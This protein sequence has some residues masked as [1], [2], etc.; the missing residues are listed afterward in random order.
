MG[1]ESKGEGII[2]KGIVRSRPKGL[3]YPEKQVQL[4]M[5]RFNSVIFD[6]DYTLADS[7]KGVVECFKYAFEHLGLP[8]APED[9]IKETIGMSLKE[10]MIHLTG[11]EHEEQSGE[12]MAL[13]KERADEVVTDLTF[14]FKEVPGVIEQ[15]RMKNIS[16]GIV[17]TK[18]RYRIEAI[19]KREN[20]LDLFDVIV[21]GEEVSKHKPDPE[22]LLV[23]LKKLKGRRE[24]TLYVGDSLIDAETAKRAGVP[25]AA[26]LSG[27]TPREAFSDYQVYAILDGLAE[28]FEIL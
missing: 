23:A 4:S 3:S 19:L 26:V 21:G 24:S 28:L 7:S 14:V 1:I 20:L 6:F 27:V 16:L 9:A 18:F 2:K 12:F 15:L 5:G 22:G 10:A 25:F 13:Y 17:S 11:L 8:A